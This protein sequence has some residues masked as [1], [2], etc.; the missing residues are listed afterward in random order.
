MTLHHDVREAHTAILI[1]VDTH[2]Q[3][4]VAVAINRLGARLADCSI[5]ADGAECVALVAWARALGDIEVFA[6]EGTGSY[7]AG[8]TSFVRRQAFRVV[9]VSHC[10]R[11]K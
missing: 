11:R 7:G 9:E 4:H 3:T 8:L 6:I 10:D 5:A 1:G 2:K